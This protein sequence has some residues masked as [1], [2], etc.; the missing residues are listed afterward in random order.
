MRDDPKFIEW[1]ALERQMLALL[2]ARRAVTTTDQFHAHNAAIDALGEQA[3]PL[4]D[5]L[6][7]RYPLD[8]LHAAARQVLAEEEARHAN[9]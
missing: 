2:V 8:A 7:V 3:Q 1:L 6:C 9:D 4:W 5:L